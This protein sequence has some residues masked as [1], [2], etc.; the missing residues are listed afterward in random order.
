MVYN[1]RLWQYGRKVFY[2]SCS[3]AVKVH[4][5]RLDCS[6]VQHT[7]DYC[8]PG[9]HIVQFGTNILE[10]HAPS[11]SLKTVRA[12]FSLTLVPVFQITQRHI[13][14]KRN[15]Y[16][17]AEM[18]SYIS[19]PSLQKVNVSMKKFWDTQA[20]RASYNRINAPNIHRSRTSLLRN[21]P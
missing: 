13:P 11:S 20:I 9:S 7:A 8:P 21:I 10:R 17:K 12:T 6:H 1:C 3:A 5:F 16:I 19:R 14:R 15:F 18:Y 2:R 4:S